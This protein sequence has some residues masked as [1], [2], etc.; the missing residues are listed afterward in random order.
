MAEIEDS[1]VENTIYQNFLLFVSITASQAHIG[2][3]FFEVW[4]DLVNFYR[5]SGSEVFF[6]FLKKVF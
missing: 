5:K 3:D 1:D 4:A 6:H 2:P